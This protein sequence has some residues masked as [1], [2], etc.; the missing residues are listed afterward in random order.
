MPDSVHLQLL[1]GIIHSLWA[2]ALLVLCFG[3]VLRWG[4]KTSAA[5]RYFAWCGACVVIAT[6]PFLLLIRGFAAG[7]SRREHLTDTATRPSLRTAAAAVPGKPPARHAAGGIPRNEARPAAIPAP[8]GATPLSVTPPAPGPGPATEDS[9]ASLASIQAAGPE[10]S[11]PQPPPH[12]QPSWRRLSAFL[13]YFPIYG[14]LPVT[15]LLLV[16]VLHG[17][18][19]LRS[20]RQRSAE[21]PEPAR[22][23]VRGW[24][25]DHGTPRA[26]EVRASRDILLPLVAGFSRPMILVPETLSAHLDSADLEQVVLHELAHV[27]RR[28]DWANLLQEII[29]ALFWWQPGLHLATARIRRERELACDDWV[30][31]QV[32]RPQI[33]AACLTRIA[34]FRLTR[35][36]PLLTPAAFSDRSELAARVESLLDTKRLHHPVPRRAGPIAGLGILGS[37]IA[38][39]LFLAPRV[40][41]AQP[42]PK[43][44]PATSSPGAGTIARYHFIGVERLSRHPDAA[45]INQLGALPTARIFRAELAQKLAAATARVLDSAGSNASLSM[46]LRPLVDD[47]LEVESAMEIRSG[48]TGQPDLALVLQPKASATSVWETNVTRLASALGWAPPRES[49]GQRGWVYPPKSPGGPWLRFLKTNDWVAIDLNRAGS[50]WRSETLLGELRKDRP[51]VP[52][53]GSKWLEMQMDLE[54]LSTWIRLP[55]TNLPTA[56]VSIYGKNDQVR[57]DGTLSW[58]RPQNWELG[59]WLIPTNTVRDPLVSFTAAQGVRSFLGPW[60]ARVGIPPPNQAFAW[61]F[62]QIPY[63]SYLAVRVPDASQSLERIARNFPTLIS[64]NQRAVA[65]GELKRPRPQELAWL[66]LPVFVPFVRGASEPGGQFLMAGVFPPPPSTNPA[67]AELFNQIVGRRN[68]LYYGWEITTERFAQ[69]NKLGLTTSLILPDLKFRT[70]SAA[71]KWLDEIAPHLARDTGQGR[72][73]DS[74]TELTVTSPTELQLT[75]RSQTGLTGLELVAFRY[76]LDHPDFPFLRSPTPPGPRRAGP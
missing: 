35:M 18:W 6:L 26:V 54:R 15:L 17:Y 7:D 75:R 21:L 10:A 32:R 65:R 9:S 14:W 61:A 30:L 39:L 36:P 55:G 59:P 8:A 60:A 5:T 23:L 3:M 38:L 64:T 40:A 19:H 25:S 51:A 44:R 11:L 28:D 47:L 66:G 34:E 68:L 2:G 72:Q 50:A 45:K 53:A 73:G 74:V 20:L 70:N 12:P 58:T 37:G 42:R 24:V 29:R 41:S 33:Y 76:L 1:D 69:W 57:S 48:Q 16:R 62:A 67:P 56:K 52:P 13:F 46:L 31:D 22:A 4:P 63:Q 43:T 71:Q 49:G 27:K